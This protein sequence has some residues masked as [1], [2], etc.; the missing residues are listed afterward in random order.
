MHGSPLSGRMN[1]T[2]GE[3]RWQMRKSAP[4]SHDE[5]MAYCCEVVAMLREHPAVIPRKVGEYCNL[6]VEG[7]RMQNP[8][9]IDL[10]V[11]GLQAVGMLAA[12]SIT[13]PSDPGGEE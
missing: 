11:W 7:C 10:G 9:I 4:M 5:G 1:A 12:T 3:K 6:I 2:P 8:Y 13:L